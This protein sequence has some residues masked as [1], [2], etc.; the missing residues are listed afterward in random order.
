[1]DSD[2]QNTVRYESVEKCT[3]RV[4]ASV[5]MKLDRA[6]AAIVETH[7]CNNPIMS[8][9]Y[10]SERETTVLRYATLVWGALQWW[11]ILDRYVVKR[12]IRS[13]GTAAQRP[14]TNSS[15]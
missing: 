4:L 7:P 9:L 3:T 10:L 11:D 8:E 15:G 12:F 5:K 6:V 13:R 2:T 14:R 1:M